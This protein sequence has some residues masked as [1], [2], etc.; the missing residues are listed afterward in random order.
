L[1]R[2]IPPLLLIKIFFISISLL[3]CTSC[4]ENTA[5]CKDFTTGTFE[6]TAII[7]GIPKTS[8]FIRN[9]AMEIDIFES[10]TDTSSV[11]WVNDCEYILTNL[12]PKNRQ[13]K[14]PM[15]IKILSTQENQYTFEF[16]QVGSSKK[17]QGIAKRI[18]NN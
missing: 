18:F 4:Y 9:E 12:H 11:R 3:L 16:S 6:Y 15:H 10:K 8:T 7:D 5:N 2:A 13:D 14:K 17:K 1:V